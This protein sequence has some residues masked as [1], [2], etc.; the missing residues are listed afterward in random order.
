MRTSHVL[1]ALLLG[2]CVFTGG[3]AL[4]SCPGGPAPK[5]AAVHGPV[6]AVPDSDSL[7]LAQGGAPSNWVEVKLAQ[8]STSYPLLMAAAFGKDA[9]CTVGA[10]GAAVCS[11]EDRPL[12]ADLQNPANIK[13]AAALRCEPTA[14]TGVCLS[15]ASPSVILAS[16]PRS[17]GLDF[18]PTP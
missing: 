4:A 9:R 6:L 2:V 7:C 15:R 16:L 10:D 1:F 18:L 17:N 14:G 11:I 13:S 5:G 12:T 8:P 3:A